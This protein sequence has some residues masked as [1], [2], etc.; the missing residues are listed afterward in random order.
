MHLFQKIVE[1]EI[2]LLGICR[3]LQVIN[4]ALGGELY[5]DIMDQ[6][7]GS[8]CHQSPDDLPRDHP[9]HSVRIESGSRLHGILGVDE[10]LVNSLHHQGISQLGAGLKATAFAP[11]GIIEAFELTGYPYGVAVQWHPEW[12]Q[13]HPS[14]RTLFRSFVQ[15]ANTS[16]K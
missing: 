1:R 14:M 13:A 12:M 11:D 8:L 7:P 6:R 10:T 16:E 3:G 15:S 4:V 9:A 5:E 2:P